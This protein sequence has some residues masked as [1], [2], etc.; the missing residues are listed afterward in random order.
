MN[1]LINDGVVSCHLVTTLSGFN[2]NGRIPTYDIPSLSVHKREVP[3]AMTIFLKLSPLLRNGT[4]SLTL[5]SESEILNALW[6]NSRL[7]QIAAKDIIQDIAF[8][9]TTNASNDFYR[10][11]PHLIFY[12]LK[13]IIS[14]YHGVSTFLHINF[15]ETA[16]LHHDLL[17]LTT[18]RTD[19]EQVHLIDF[20]MIW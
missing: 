13:I 17:N 5:Y 11:I 1:D 3:D 2:R 18:H 9:T 19:D 4:T 15:Y 6:I 16:I 8:P 20:S 7:K 14:F 10:P 12:F